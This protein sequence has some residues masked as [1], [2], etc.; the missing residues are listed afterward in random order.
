MVMRQKKNEWR[1]EQ[2]G[3]GDNVIYRLTRSWRW[4][5][6]VVLILAGTAITGHFVRSSAEGQQR[7][8]AEQAPRSVFAPR[9]DNRPG[10]AFQS[11]DNRLDRQA[12]DIAQQIRETEDATKRSSLQE[13]LREVTMR[14]FELRQAQSARSIKD[15]QRKLT[16]LQVTWEKRQSNANAIVARR[17]NDLTGVG[18][19][20][21]WD[22]GGTS[23]Q[24]IFSDVNR[25]TSQTRNNS[26][27]G[28]SIGRSSSGTSIGNASPT[29]TP[30]ANNGNDYGSG[31]QRGGNDYGSGGQRD[32]NDYG[33][34]G[35]RDGNDYGSG[36]Q[37]GGNDYGSGGQRSSNH[38]NAQSF[39][40]GNS[41]Q[42]VP[43][44]M[45]GKS[46]SYNDQRPADQGQNAPGGIGRLNDRT[47]DG[48][49]GGIGR[50]N[51]RTTDGSP[52]RIGRPNDRATDGSTSQRRTTN[53]SSYNRT[54]NSKSRN[55][56]VKIVG[57]D[58][59][60]RT[61]DPRATH[62]TAQDAFQSAARGLLLA[63]FRT[64]SLQAEIAKQQ[65]ILNELQARRA[66]MEAQ[67]AES[68]KV[69]D[70]RENGDEEAKPL[71]FNDRDLPSK[72]RDEDRGATNKQD[73]DDHSD[74]TSTTDSDTTSTKD[75]DA[76][77]TTDSDATSTAADSDAT[78]SSSD[79]KD[80]DAAN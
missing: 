51:D 34:G 80:E 30:N 65:A 63:P 56:G 17:F 28:Y 46:Q 68:Y 37:R 55:E 35:Q 23:Q 21:A 40:H 20:L 76:T 1:D 14:H 38:G 12:R 27:Y 25:Q 70:D 52:G 32:G 3:K 22:Q 67:K 19:A 18:D 13:A 33:S 29:H 78:E 42:Q 58:G 47:T 6:T 54:S 71:N 9:D 48:S 8:D 57:D 41:Q 5:F 31:G 69:V 43:H 59:S 60:S 10:Q 15:L 16:E 36:G 49:P 7:R 11:E 73:G 45:F 61:Q 26:Q 66:A 77:S 62:P 50:L 2:H 39:D 53:D 4:T 72:A 44:S 75:S 24:R 74:A 79:L 64:R